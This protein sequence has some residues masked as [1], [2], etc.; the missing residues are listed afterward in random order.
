M[1]GLEVD[2]RCSRDMIGRQR[3]HEDYEPEYFDEIEFEKTLQPS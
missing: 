3:I 2:S 1:D